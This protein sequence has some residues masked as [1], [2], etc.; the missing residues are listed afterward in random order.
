MNT[1]EKGKKAYIVRSRNRLKEVAKGGARDDVG[2]DTDLLDKALADVQGATEDFA[3]IAGETIATLRADLAAA[4]KADDRR[5]PLK[6]IQAQAHEL[7]NQG[8]TF[9]YPL[10]SRVATSLYRYTESKG[11]A[12]DEHLTVIKAHIDTLATLL[13]HKVAGDGGEV[14]KALLKALKEAI[15]KHERP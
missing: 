6:R 2:F 9:G 8:G 12:S 10:V 5:T 4:G 11:N 13:H 3:T 7:R 14:G 1:P 15:L